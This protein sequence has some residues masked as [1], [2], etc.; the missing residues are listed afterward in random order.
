MSEA[1]KVCRGACCESV[2]IPISPDPVHLAYWNARG[3]LGK[4]GETNCVE[5]VHRCPKLLS[6]G[7]CKIYNDR[8]SACSDHFPVGN[9]FCR[10]AIQTR[11]AKDASRILALLPTQTQ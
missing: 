7:K 2:I 5:L 8:P 3:T 11:R 6:S 10:L 4:I 1:C 9:A